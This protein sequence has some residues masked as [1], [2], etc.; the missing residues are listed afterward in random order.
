MFKGKADLAKAL[1]GNWGI[2]GNGGSCGK[3]RKIPK[4]QT[5]S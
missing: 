2:G 4:V 1:F 5:F 3:P